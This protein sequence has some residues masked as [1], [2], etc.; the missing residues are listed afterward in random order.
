MGNGTGSVHGNDEHGL[1]ELIPKMV[2]EA[3]LVAGPEVI[4]MFPVPVI[5]PLLL[6]VNVPLTIKVP[7]TVTL[8]L[9]A[10]L[11]KVPFT[12]TLEPA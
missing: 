1:A 7:L 6:L 5:I 9:P 4:Y 8:L 10:L 12:V 3:P 2:A 11:I